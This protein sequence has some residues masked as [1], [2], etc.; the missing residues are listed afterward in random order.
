MHD[1][2]FSDIVKHFP[3][4]IKEYMVIPTNFILRYIPKKIKKLCTEKQYKNVPVVLFIIAK[5][6]K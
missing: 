3:F 6:W 2:E 5:K 4:A 1:Y